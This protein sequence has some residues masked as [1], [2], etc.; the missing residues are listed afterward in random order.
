[1][2]Y[3]HKCF[4]DRRLP[5]TPSLIETLTLNLERV[6]P[7]PHR[8]FN[9]LEPGSVQRQLGLC[10]GR[11][12]VIH[13]VV[14]VSHGENKTA[15]GE[16]GDIHVWPSVEKGRFFA[17]DHT[18]T[19]RTLAQID[20]APPFCCFALAQRLS[21]NNPACEQHHGNISQKHG[22]C[23]CAHLKT[24]SL[25]RNYYLDYHFVAFTAISPIFC[26]V[27]LRVSSTA[28]L[29]FT[30][31]LFVG[32]ETK[33]ETHREGLFVCLFVI[34]MA[35]KAKKSAAVADSSSSSGGGNA[36]KCGERDGRFLCLMLPTI[37]THQQQDE[38]QFSLFSNRCFFMLLSQLF[39]DNSSH[40]TR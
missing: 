9:Y 11:S 13:Q 4:F 2:L 7:C 36:T 21:G 34:I 6:A 38:R 22:G 17:V 12:V 39:L 31:I 5:L 3:A 24:N 25:L 19:G 29:G 16:A 8:Q 14:P 30:I 35:P 15:C 23:C 32:G 1:M 27:T 40:G 18:P 10:V 20:L 26:R 33:N 37:T 28:S